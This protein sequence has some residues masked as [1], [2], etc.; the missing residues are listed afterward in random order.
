MD[1]ESIFASEIKK[2]EIWVREIWKNW[3]AQGHYHNLIW[4]NYL[5]MDPEVFEELLCM[6]Q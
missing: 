4:S 3:D 1:E 5:C 2:K 6:V